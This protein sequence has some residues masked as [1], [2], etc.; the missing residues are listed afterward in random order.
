MA[1]RPNPSM[2]LIRVPIP[3]ILRRED[4]SNIPILS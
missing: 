4:K 1:A 3:D 2:M